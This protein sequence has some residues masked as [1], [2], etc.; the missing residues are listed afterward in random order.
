MFILKNH[1]GKTS[2]SVITCGFCFTAD[3]DHLIQ[4]IYNGR[5]NKYVKHR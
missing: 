5:S 4:N 3:L 2:F 1:G